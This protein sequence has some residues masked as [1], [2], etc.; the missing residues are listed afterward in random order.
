M[1]READSEF[2]GSALLLNLFKKGE[3]FSALALVFAVN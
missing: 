2:L 3:P 1:R